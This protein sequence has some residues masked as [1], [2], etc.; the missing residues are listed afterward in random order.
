MS[1]GADSPW[2]TCPDCAGRGR[3]TDRIDC[4][5]CHGSGHDSAGMTEH[6]FR[7]DNAPHRPCRRCGGSGKM[8][9]P[10]PCP[11]CNGAGVVA[12][13]TDA[14]D[15][16]A[17]LAAYRAFLV[18]PAQFRLS[19]A[20]IRQ[21]THGLERLEALCKAGHAR[22]AVERLELLKAGNWPSYS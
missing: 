7:M 6:E 2:V 3:L 12:P 14:P 13:D 10:A 15:C 17:T 4:T 22:L 11:L 18:G 21:Q 16:L 9:N 8:A 1:G 5:A 20:N 19:P